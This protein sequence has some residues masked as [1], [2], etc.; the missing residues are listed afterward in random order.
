M[1]EELEHLNLDQL[2]HG[3]QAH[4][5]GHGWQSAAVRR[6]SLKPDQLNQLGLPPTPPVTA[7]AA[8]AGERRSSCS[9][10]S[11]SASTSP[12]GRRSGRTSI[13][14]APPILGNLLFAEALEL[15][16]L[17][18]Y[19]L[20][21]VE[22]PV[23]VHN[24]GSFVVDIAPALALSLSVLEAAV[25]SG[26]LRGTE[27]RLASLVPTREGG[28]LLDGLA[29]L[30]KQVD[31]AL[32]ASVGTHDFAPQLRAQL[33]A[34]EAPTA[35][36]SPAGLEAVVGRTSAAFEAVARE[37]SS[38]GVLKQLPMLPQMAD[39]GTLTWVSESMLRRWLAIGAI[40]VGGL[41]AHR[42]LTPLSPSGSAPQSAPPEAPP[43]V[44]SPCDAAF[45][46]LT[47]T[48]PA[49]SGSAVQ[50]PWYA[51]TPTDPW[52]EIRRRVWLT[53]LSLTKGASQL[54]GCV[55]AT[56]GCAV[57]AVQQSSRWV[58]TAGERCAVT[59]ADAQRRCAV[60]VTKAQRQL[61]CGSPVASRRGVT[62]APEVELEIALCA[63]CA[64]ADD[65]VLAAA[66]TLA[67][68]LPDAVV[69]NPEAWEMQLTLAAELAALNARA[70]AA[71]AR[72]GR[73]GAEDAMESTRRRTELAEQLRLEGDARLEVLQQEV[74]QLE[75]ARL[76][77]LLVLA[78]LEVESVQQHVG[79]AAQRKRAAA[80]VRPPSHIPLHLPRAPL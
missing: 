17:C 41:S 18:G 49:P 71:M 30:R 78:Q 40:R 77:V 79:P 27:G 47:Q 16:F 24:P 15:R 34:L 66:E 20:Q 57:D 38:Q 13:G 29:T 70:T 59:T 55:G 19:D 10:R 63:A 68:A 36:A 28:T 52:A 33:E 48:P 12:A 61:G 76:R 11:S 80:Q 4:S 21:P 9:G 73:G 32:A 50:R 74:Q 23:V 26:W 65:T 46:C 56:W 14:G 8:A 42:A 75:S 37:A 43:H 44:L 72:R 45:Y 31:A 5:L 58:L 1:A 53:R 67:A 6:A 54:V 69:Q 39:D 60:A 62:V 64:V 3:L 7:E 25:A 35:G 2:D 22:P 51:G